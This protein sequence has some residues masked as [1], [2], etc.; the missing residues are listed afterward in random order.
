ML[1]VDSLKQA[2]D[3][4]REDYELKLKAG[5]SETWQCDQRTKDLW[6]LGH[7]I[8]AR[9]CDLEP[10]RRRALGLMFNRIVRSVED[11]FEAAVVVIHV[12]DSDLNIE[13][14]SKDYWTAKNNNKW[15]RP[16]L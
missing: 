8:D 13:D 7:F 3:L 6:C 2:L 12:G 1:T 14:Y 4:L 16:A 15:N 5:Q 9:Y 10:D 11:P